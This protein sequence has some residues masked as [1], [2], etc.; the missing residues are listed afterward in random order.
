MAR[1]FLSG[2]DVLMIAKADFS[3]G[4]DYFQ[5]LYAGVPLE[6]GPYVRQGGWFNYWLGKIGD[7][8]GVIDTWGFAVRTSQDVIDQ[9]INEL[10][11][12]SFMQDEADAT[13]WLI[14]PDMKRLVT[15]PLSGAA[16]PAPE[17]DAK[18]PAAPQSDKK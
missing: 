10:F 12:I 9:R 1:A 18:A 14:A 17:G 3:G 13:K 6:R 8:Q 11:F 16:A 5:A 4:W 7:A 2:I 15:E